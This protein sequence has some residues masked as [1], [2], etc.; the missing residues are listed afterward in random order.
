MKAPGYEIPRDST[1]H[2]LAETLVKKGCL[3]NKLISWF[4]AVTS[5]ANMASHKDYPTEKDMEDCR[6]RKRVILTLYLGLQLLEELDNVFSPR[7]FHEPAV[8]FGS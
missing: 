7:I 4:D 8:Y 1:I 3:D 2:K 5:V 6:T